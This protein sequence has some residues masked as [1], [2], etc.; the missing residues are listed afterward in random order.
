MPLIFNLEDKCPCGSGYVLKYCCIPEVLPIV[1]GTQTRVKLERGPVAEVVDAVG[2]AIGYTYSD[3]LGISMR[4]T[5]R[6]YEQIDHAIEQLIFSHLSNKEFAQ[7]IA[8][9]ADRYTE[10]LDALWN[11]LH[12]V[13][14]HQR[15][16]L[17]RLQ[18]LTIEHTVD[19]AMVQPGQGVSITYEDVPLRLELESMVFRLIGTLD[20]FAKIIGVILGKDFSND[21][22]LW[23]YLKDTHKK[24]STSKKLY[25]IYMSYAWIRELKN[26]RN[27]IAH[28]G[29]FPGFKSLTFEGT[30]F[31]LPEV[32]ELRANH[33]AFK[34]W[35]EIVQMTKAVLQVMVEHK[36]GY[37]SAPD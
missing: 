5:V 24:R 25:D 2:N 7:A 15:N 3:Q 36:L 1:I 29:T 6:K 13:R 16:F 12:A 22:D 32:N 8:D 20:V 30:S 11:V 37:E 19:Y 18:K 28:D 34:V 26:L 21:K 9:M 35:R 14:Y 4:T 27:A 17:Y 23:G 31:E 33:M 10:K